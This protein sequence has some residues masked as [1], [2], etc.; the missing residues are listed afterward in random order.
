MLFQSSPA[1]SSGR[2]QGTDGAGA[3][4]FVSI[5][6]RPFERALLRHCSRKI[7]S[8]L[9]QSSPALSSGRYSAP[10]D[11]HRFS[12]S[13]NP[14]PPFRAG[15]TEPFRQTLPAYRSFNPRPPFR[16]GAT[17]T[18]QRR[19]RCKP[20]SILARPFER[21]LQHRPRWMA[22]RF[23]VSILARPFE[24]ALPMA[25]IPAPAILRVSILAR[26]FERALRDGQ[27]TQRVDARFQSSPALSSGRYVTA[28]A[29]RKEALLF[30][31]S[32]ALS[33]GRYK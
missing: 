2:Y 30:Q 15:A 11:D 6:A 21:A 32:P 8:P 29:Q 9:F 3:G 4:L 18:R 27:M 12:I 14:R 33:S 26:P 31:S 17:A 19:R 23:P 22:E 16:A 10:M 7:T 28:I 20:V 25:I 13:F 5:L 24:R 1:L